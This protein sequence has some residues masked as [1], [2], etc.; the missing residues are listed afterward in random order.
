MNCTVCLLV[1]STNDSYLGSIISDCSK[2][3][4]KVWC[5]PKTQDKMRNEGSQ[6]ICEKCF[7]TIDGPIVLSLPS[8]E[9]LSVIRKTLIERN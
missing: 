3:N 6:I 7:I 2:C 1:K 5:S 4:R 9:E 8:R